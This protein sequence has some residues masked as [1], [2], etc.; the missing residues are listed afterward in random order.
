[1]ENLTTPPEDPKQ[2]GRK[3]R[4]AKAKKG[5]T[6]ETMPALAPDSDDLLPALDDLTTTIPAPAPPPTT[7][8]PTTSAQETMD[9]LRSLLS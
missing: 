9:D 5:A 4:G 7:P 2:Q 3:K 1:M 6:Q 8:G